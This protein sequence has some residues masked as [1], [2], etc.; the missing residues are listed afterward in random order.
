MFLCHLFSVKKET[1][2]ASYADYN[3]GYVTV[4]T[5]EDV[6]KTFEKRFIIL[7]Q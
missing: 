1:D 5:L 7:F 3:I 6:I 4:A 2:F